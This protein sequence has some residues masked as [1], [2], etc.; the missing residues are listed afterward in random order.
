MCGL[1]YALLHHQQQLN[2]PSPPPPQVFINI[3]H[4]EKIGQ[5]TM[6]KGEKGTAVSLPHALG[7]M[8]QEKDKKGENVRT[9]DVCF[10]STAIAMAR[11]QKPFKDIIVKT[12]MEGVEKIMAQTAP[13]KLEPQCVAL[14]LL[15]LLLLLPAPQLTSR[16]PAAPGTTSSRASST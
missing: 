14:P 16:R 10:A 12:A 15:L 6:T 1:Y 7:P 2:P 13:M 11:G 8:R 5:P 3:V 9:Y 4:D